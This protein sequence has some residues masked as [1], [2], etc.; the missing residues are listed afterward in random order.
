MFD[1]ENNVFWPASWGERPDSVAAR[2]KIVKGQVNEWPQFVPLYGHRYLPAAPSGPGA[3]VF[4]V[5]QADVIIYGSN[6]LDY[7]AREF[8]TPRSIPSADVETYGLE[9][10]SFL[11]FEEGIP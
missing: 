6:L 5:H 11:A 2:F 4:S 3:P 7:A 1:V 8:G 9:S 10:W